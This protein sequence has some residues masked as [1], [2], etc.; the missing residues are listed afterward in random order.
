V[1]QDDRFSGSLRGDGAGGES[2]EGDYD[3]HGPA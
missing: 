3:F 1:D 2:E